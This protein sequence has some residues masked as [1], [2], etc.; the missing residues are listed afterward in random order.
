MERALRF[1]RMHFLSRRH[2]AALVASAAAIGAVTALVYLLRPR[3]PVESLGALYV[4]AVLPAAVMF[5]RVAALLVAVGS[6]IVFNFLHLPP[7]HTLTLSAGENWLVFS[8][9]VVTGVLVAELAGRARQRARDAEQREREAAL[10]A[11]LST[12]LLSGAE[13]GSELPRIAEG[14]ARILQT[15]RARIGLGPPERPRPGEELVPLVTDDRVVGAVYVPRGTAVPSS[16]LPR[17]L[18]ALASLLAVALDRERLAHEALEAEA[19]RRSDSIKT[20][21]LRSVSHDLR[22]PLTAIRVA[23]ESLSSPALTLDPADRDALLD[24]MRAEVT[25]LDRVVGNLLDVSR[26]QAGAVRPE[27]AL[28]TL[29]SVVV[30]ALGG[31]EGHERVDATL[32]D[33]LPLLDVDAVQIERVLVNL[34]EN[35]LKF[36]PPGSPVRVSAAA[37]P[38]EVVIR[39][40]DEG[41]GLPREELERVFEPFRQ[42]S[43]ASAKGTGLGL[44]IVRGFAEANGG[45]VHAERRPR[46]GTAFVLTLPAVVA[47]VGA[48]A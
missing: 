24:A 19:L 11:E 10:L 27:R 47:P 5:G 29:E 6:M 2:V 40:D 1:L 9:Y 14:A 22:S 36:S 45:R 42:A 30:P 16:I 12:V 34:L 23:V 38:G 4:L 26:L 8:V 3:V 33:D 44:A 46:G 39:V 28:C 31:L 48:P 21:V 43:A 35:A 18:P 13:V 37:Q 20:A 41:P 32:P 15:D 17:F 25:R 7:V